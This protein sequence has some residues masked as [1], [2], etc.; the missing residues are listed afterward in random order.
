[1]LTYR[2]LLSFLSGGVAVA[3]SSLVIALLLLKEDGAEAFAVFSLYQLTWTFSLSASTAILFN[4]CA[5][6]VV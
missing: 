6:F 3:I 5:Q 4:L 1:M 2:K